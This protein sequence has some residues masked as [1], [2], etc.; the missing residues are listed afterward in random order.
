MIR[1]HRI[2]FFLEF[3]KSAESVHGIGLVSGSIFGL[4]LTLHLAKRIFNSQLAEIF[5]KHLVEYC[6]GH[7]GNSVIDDL[8]LRS[9]GESNIL[10][11]VLLESAA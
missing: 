9:G 7:V 6:I 8:S 1:N 2:L 10:R 4:L 3:N 11:T 5:I